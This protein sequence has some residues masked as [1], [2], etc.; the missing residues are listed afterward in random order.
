MSKF[1]RTSGFKWIDHKEFDLTK[2][3]INDSKGCV[4]EDDPE[5]PKELRELH[6]GSLQI[7][8]K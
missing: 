3:T 2:Y 6:N 4:L 8:E 1:L 5:Y 7:K